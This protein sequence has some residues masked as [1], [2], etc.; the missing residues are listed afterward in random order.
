[1]AEGVS[2]R[3]NSMTRCRTLT[4][5]S[6]DLHP[7]LSTPNPSSTNLQANPFLTFFSFFRSL[8]L[9][10]VRIVAAG[11]DMQKYHIAKAEVK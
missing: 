3:D 1:M 9:D 11:L 6:S 5:L 2:Q 10:A 4:E 8:I 7:Y